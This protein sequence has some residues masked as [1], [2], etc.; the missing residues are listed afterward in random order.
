MF[1]FSKIDAVFAFCFSKTPGGNF[2]VTMGCRRLK[3]MIAATI[4]TSRTKKN[5]IKPG[6][7]QRRLVFE[8]FAASLSMVCGMVKN[9]SDRGESTSIFFK[10]FRI[11]LNLIILYSKTA[12]LRIRSQTGEPFENGSELGISSRPR[13][14]VFCSVGASQTSL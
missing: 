7:N 3:I 13:I 8:F 11:E 5:P 12:I 6:I 9:S 14:I 4:M 2:L 1:D 10:A